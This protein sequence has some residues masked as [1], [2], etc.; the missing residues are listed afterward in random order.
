MACIDLRTVYTMADCPLSPLLMIIS[1]G[2]GP[3]GEAG[4]MVPTFVA[5]WG[6]TVHG[7]VPL[8]TMDEVGTLGDIEPA[9]QGWERENEMIWY[10]SVYAI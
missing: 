4:R 3:E 2:R 7:D 9:C 10:V 1:S 6:S 8:A 5:T